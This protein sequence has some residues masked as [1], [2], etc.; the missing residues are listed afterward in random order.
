MTNDRIDQD[1]GVTQAAVLRLLGYAT[2]CADFEAPQHARSFAPSDWAPQ[3]FCRIQMYL[4]RNDR[5]R[6]IPPLRGGKH[7]NWTQVV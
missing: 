6:T 1:V 4:L 7:H 5:R 2:V 3:P